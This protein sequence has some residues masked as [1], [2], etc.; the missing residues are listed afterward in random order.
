MLERQ[1]LQ[2]RMANAA[3]DIYLATCA[4]SRATTA[5]ERSAG[6]TKASQSDVDCARLFV[7]TAFRRARRA[8]WGL[9]ENQDSLIRSV[10]A[11]SLEEQELGTAPPIV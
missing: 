4:L 10:A 5:I 7:S 1:L 3:I 9:R 6:D 11:R 8:L 2:E